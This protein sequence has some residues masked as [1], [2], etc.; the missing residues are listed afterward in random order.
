MKSQQAKVQHFKY[1][2][3]STNKKSPQQ[4]YKKAVGKLRYMKKIGQ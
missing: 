1:G 4:N 2:G 3:G